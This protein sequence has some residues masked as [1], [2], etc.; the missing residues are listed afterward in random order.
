M[1]VR[2]QCDASAMPVRCWCDAVLPPPSQATPY[3]AE[4]H[5]SLAALGDLSAVKPG[6]PELIKRIGAATKAGLA[7]LKEAAAPAE[8]AP[9]SKL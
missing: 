4:A 9:A 7:A 2:C 6:D 3:H 5:A 1:P 8:G